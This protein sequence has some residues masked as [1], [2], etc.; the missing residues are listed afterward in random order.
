MWCP[1]VQ[2]GCCVE[3]GWADSDPPWRLAH[4]TSELTLG[5]CGRRRGLAQGAQE[6]SVGHLQGGWG[7]GTQSRETVGVPARKV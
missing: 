3:A 7:R 5:G 6:A 4:G 2:S 1:V